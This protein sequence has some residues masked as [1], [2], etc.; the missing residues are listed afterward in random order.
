ME[1]LFLELDE[2]IEIHHDQLARY[3]GQD[4]IRDIGLLTSA[5]AQPR[6]TFGGRFL[7]VDLPAMAAAYLFH[8]A[9]NHPFVDGNKR[10]GAMCAYAF[11]ALNDLDLDASEAAFEALVWQVARGEIGKDQVAEF[12]RAHVVQAG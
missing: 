1:P 2:V 9:Q 10:T 3:G 4:G 5:L 11:L 6:A 12:V 8:V 7:H